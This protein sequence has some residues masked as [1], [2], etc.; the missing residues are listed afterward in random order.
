MSHVGSCMCALT[1]RRVLN[2]PCLALM[3][4]ARVSL[5]PGKSTPFPFRSHLVLQ[6]KVRGLLLF[7]C[8]SVS[9]FEMGSGCDVQADLNLLSSNSTSILA[10]I[11]AETIGTN[12]NS[13]I[14]LV[15]V[16]TLLLN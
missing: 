14:K 15:H 4:P 6:M 16:D 9:F 13:L 10:S 1:E 8:L 2:G 11:V 7:T 12:W 3:D 5:D